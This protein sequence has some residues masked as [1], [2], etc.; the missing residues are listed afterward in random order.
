[1]KRSDRQ[2]SLRDPVASDF[3]QQHRGEILF[4]G[5][6]AP[7]SHTNEQTLRSYGVRV[8][9]VG[10]VTNVTHKRTKHRPTDLQFSD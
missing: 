5:I 7:R 9:S 2:S 3:S 1:M 4:A 6:F 10:G 8:V